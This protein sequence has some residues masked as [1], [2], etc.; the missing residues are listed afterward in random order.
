MIEIL[1]HLVDVLVKL[2]NQLT[3]FGSDVK[4]LRSKLVCVFVRKHAAH[5]LNAF[6]ETLHGLFKAVV[7]SIVNAF[8]YDFLN[9]IVEESECL[10]GHLV[11]LWVRGLAF[12]LGNQADHDLVEK[13]SIIGVV[14]V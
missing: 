8:A 3:D 5:I 4:N 12:E 13:W 6:L 2:L 9:L 14:D 10:I 1:F 11:I 7:A